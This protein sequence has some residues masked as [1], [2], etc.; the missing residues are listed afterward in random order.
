VWWFLGLAVG[1]A[2]FV[3]IL[4]KFIVSYSEQIFSLLFESKHRDSETIAATGCAPPEWKRN[5]VIRLFGG[6]VGKRIADRRIRSIIRYFET[7]RLVDGENARADI[8]KQLQTTREIWKRK[9]WDEICP[10][11]S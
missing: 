8:V 6:R 10:Y 4:F 3:A 2:I 9:T 11:E 7:T 5:A 1:G